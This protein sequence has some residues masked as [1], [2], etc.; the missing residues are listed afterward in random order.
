MYHPAV[1]SFD[2]NLYICETCHKDL[3]K[4]ETPCQA[5]RNKMAL[6]PPPNEL[7]DLKKLEKVLISKRNLFEKLA[8]MDEKGEFSKIK[9]FEPVCPHIIYQLL[10]YLKSYSKFY[11]DISFEKDLSSAEM[12][13]FSDIV[14][15]QGENESVTIPINFDG[16]EMSESKNATK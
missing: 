12:L 16:T 1:K 3:Y 13:R 9:G 5:V 4:N 7:K 15:V 8:V 14:E 6:N 2:K 11:A 10:T